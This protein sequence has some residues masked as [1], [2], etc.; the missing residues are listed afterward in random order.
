MFAM[1]LFVV[2]QVPVDARQKDVLPFPRRRQL[3]DLDTDARIEAKAVDLLSGERKAVENS[4]LVGVPDRH[5]IG[6][7]AGESS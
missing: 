5:G 4:F 6:P 3:L 2:R 7:V 1:V